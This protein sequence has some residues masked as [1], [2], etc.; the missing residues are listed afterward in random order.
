MLTLT[1]DARLAIAGLV[2]PMGPEGHGGVR[3]AVQPSLDGEGPELNLAVAS[4][5]A[6]GD[7]VID[8][9]GARVFLD[10][11][12]AALLEASTLD[13]HIDQ[14]AQQVDFFLA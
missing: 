4:E 10:A 1:N 12:A 5:P 11:S 13:A 3:I 9:N 8:E 14:T 7:S 6:P 2:E